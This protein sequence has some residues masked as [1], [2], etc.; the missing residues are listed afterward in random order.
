MVG[1]PGVGKTSLCR[2]VSQLKGYHYINYGEL[3]LEFAEKGEHKSTQEEM[4]KLPLETQ[5][6]IWLE[7][8]HY[9]KYLTDDSKNECDDSAVDSKREY[10]DL[11]EDKNYSNCVLVDLHGLDRSKTGYLISLPLEIIKPQI[12][13]VV[14]SRYDQIIQ[15]RTNDPQRIRFLEGLKSL[16]QDMELLRNSMA[17]CS[18]M[19]G[20]FCAVL[21][22][23]EFEESLIRLQKYL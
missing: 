7:A 17:V 12:I 8:A 10:G 11:A 1:V 20:S 21:E 14:E 4:F 16:N 13:I 9:I 18:A 3:M 2:E 5:Y 19:L 6:N 15:Q 22:N 23:D